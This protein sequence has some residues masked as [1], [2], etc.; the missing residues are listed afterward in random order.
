VIRV[1]NLFTRPCIEDKP[2]DR[3]LITLPGIMVHYMGTRRALQEALEQPQPP[4]LM[5]ELTAMQT[6]ATALTEL[7][8]AQARLRVLRWAECFSAVPGAPPPAPA[9]QSM[10]LVAALQSGGTDST[11]TLDGFDLFGDTPAFDHTHAIDDTPAFDDTPSDEA[12]PRA[13]HTTGEPLDV[14]IKGI[15]ADVQQIARDWNRE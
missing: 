8:D 9:A 14:L 1:T 11:L 2:T 12:E 6:I 3:V 4:D 5:A 7:S 10:P 13:P 15:A